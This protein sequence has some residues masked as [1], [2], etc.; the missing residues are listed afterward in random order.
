M[1]PL[2]VSIHSHLLEALLPTPGWLVNKD[3]VPLTG[4]FIVTACHP[5]IIGIFLIL[6]GEVFPTNIRSVSIGI[7]HALQC[8]V[9]AFATKAFPLLLE[10]LDFY[11]LNYYYSALSV[12]MTIWGMVT[13]KDIDRL[14]LVEIEWIYNKRCKTSEMSSN[15]NGS[16]ASNY[17]SIM[18]TDE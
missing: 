1:P 6:V 16:K 13:I 2:T 11:G 14:S 12:A 17:G 18:A 8:L 4:F 15:A 10:W 9:L 5:L 7:V 3:W